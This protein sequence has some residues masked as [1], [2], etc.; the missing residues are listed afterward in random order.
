MSG[1]QEF[2]Q[3][4]L[5]QLSV[6]LIIIFLFILVSIFDKRK[7]D[8]KSLAMA[9]MLA[10]LSSLLSFVVIFRAPLDGS[11]T[12][13]AMLPI[14]LAGYLLGG[15][16]GIV[17]G[18]TVGFINLLVNPYVI[19]PIQLI[20]D[21]PLAFGALGIGSVFAIGKK[22]KLL[23][24]LWIGIVLRFICAFLSGIIFFAD[25]VPANWNVL[26]FSAFYNSSYL[27]AEGIII[28]VIIMLPPFAK[29][30]ESIKEKRV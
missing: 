15:R 19:H 16:V 28:S 26:A 23:M 8:S 13:G 7:L 6:I 20:L 3:S 25:T 12:L 17:V 5:G 30:I 10:A 24:A 1:L 2:F 21:Y 18:I 27:V 9:A 14:V 11:V 29:F 22:Y 4:F